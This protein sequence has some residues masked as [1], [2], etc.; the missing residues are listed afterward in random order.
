MLIQ[1]SQRFGCHLAYQ[2]V[3]GSPKSGKIRMDQTANWRIDFSGDSVAQKIVAPGPNRLIFHLL[4]AQSAGK[5]S[6]V[7]QTGEWG[8]EESEGAA[9]VAA[10]I[11]QKNGTKIAEKIKFNW[12]NIFDYKR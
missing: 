9:G 12:C 11:A 10:K 4:P 1:P 3:D 6:T 7:E 2:T 8:V 5:R